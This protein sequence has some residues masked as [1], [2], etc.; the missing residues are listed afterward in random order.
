MC[1]K[2]KGALNSIIEKIALLVIKIGSREV[3]V[4]LCGKCG[5]EEIERWQNQ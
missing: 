4:L 3:R 2:C 5:K 1:D